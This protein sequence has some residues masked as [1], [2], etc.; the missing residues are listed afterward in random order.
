MSFYAHIPYSAKI[1]ELKRKK[2]DG[3]RKEDGSGSVLAS[4]STTP[5]PVESRGTAGGGIEADQGAEERGGAEE[6]QGEGE[7]EGR[8]VP[9]L[10][11]GADGNIIIDEERYTVTFAYCHFSRTW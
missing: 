2:E 11:I 1:E 3:S 10:R 4:K 5:V 9:K 6:G 8:L 7:E